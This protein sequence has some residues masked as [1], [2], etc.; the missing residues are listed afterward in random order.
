MR[1]VKLT[2]DMR[3]WRAGDKVPLATDLADKL[4]LSGEASDAGPWPPADVASG[5]GDVATP[6]RRRAQGVRTK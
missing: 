2:K 4:I 1:M 6:A 5:L 3:P